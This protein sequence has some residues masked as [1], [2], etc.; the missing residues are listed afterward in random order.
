MEK[1]RWFRIVMMISFAVSMLCMS[2]HPYEEG[3]TSYTVVNNLTSTTTWGG[4]DAYVYEYTVDDTRVD[5]NVI[6][7]PK[8]GKK[9]TFYPA[10][11]IDH[12]KLRLLSSENTE[13]WGDT[14]FYLTK[15]EN[16][17]INVNIKFVTNYRFSEPMP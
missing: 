1:N 11:S 6:K 14:I 8:V 13:R 17:M 3:R 2:C 7:N 12:L 5:S 10:D 9:Y 15:D 4:L 16:I